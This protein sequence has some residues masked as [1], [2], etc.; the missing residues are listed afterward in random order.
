MNNT[1][2][3]MSTPI[4]NIPIKTKNLEEIND[5]TIEN[6][7]KDFKNDNIETNNNINQEDLKLQEQML[8]EQQLEQ[9]KIEE[10][11]IKEKILLEQQIKQNMENKNKSIYN[12]DFEKEMENLMDS[13]DLLNLDETID[14][15]NK[16]IFNKNNISNFVIIIVI[17]ILIKNIDIL[18]LIEKN[19][20]ENILIILTNNYTFINILC[21]F[22]ILYLLYYFEYI[23]I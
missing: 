21:T 13:S 1:T 17:Y 12:N 15:D 3:S 5:P 8:Y 23:K 10:E 4:N 6:I 18:K 11:R 7:F 19:I 22:I 20:P 2:S 9:Q 14:K 16:N